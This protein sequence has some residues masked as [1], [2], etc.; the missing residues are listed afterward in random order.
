MASS[1]YSAGKVCIITEESGVL[2]YLFPGSDDDLRIGEMEREEEEEVIDRG[3]NKDREGRESYMEVRTDR[4]T[5]VD[6][7]S[8]CDS[9]DDDESLLAPVTTQCGVQR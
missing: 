3:G 5:K 4:D 1:H 8:E 6:A 7:G 2:E 9:S